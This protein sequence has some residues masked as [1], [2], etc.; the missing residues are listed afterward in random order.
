MH[1]ADDDQKESTKQTNR[2]AAP[3]K[4]QHRAKDDKHEGA[5]E[6]AC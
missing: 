1:K 6:D 2:K 5:C 3:D 4:L